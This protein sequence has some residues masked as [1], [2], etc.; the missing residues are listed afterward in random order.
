M[1]PTM[2]PLTRRMVHAGHTIAFDVRGEGDRVVVLLPGMLM[3]RVMYAPL[4]AG[5]AMDGYR[6]VC[7]DPLGHGES[8]RPEE[9]WNYSVPLFARQV[10]ALLDELE[11]HS[12]VVGGASLGANVAL[13]TA[14]AAPGRVRGLV[15]EMPVLDSAL[16][17]CAAFLTPMLLSLTLGAPMLRLLAV[18]VRR[19]PRRTT[20]LADML[21]ELL[22]QRPEPSAAVVKG[23]FFGRTAPPRDERLGITQP[24]MVIGHPHDPLHPMSDARLLAGEL[25]HARLVEAKSIAEL[26]LV[27]SRLSGKIAAFLEDCFQPEP[28][29]VVGQTWASSIRGPAA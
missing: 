25:P 14:V 16:A 5:L 24:A 18:L 11:V 23:I 21:L 1:L 29:A 28:A 12:A 7:L 4:A 17:T 3:S 20:L 8:G 2:H 22:S 9:M 6:V 13:E 19:A 15:L 26:R 27:P 10:V